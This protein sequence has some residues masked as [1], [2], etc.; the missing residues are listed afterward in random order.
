MDG[1]YVDTKHLFKGFHDPELLNPDTIGSFG[2]FDI[3]Y[4]IFR[5]VE[6]FEK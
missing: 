2:S 6:K 5:N 4:I 1:W 3:N